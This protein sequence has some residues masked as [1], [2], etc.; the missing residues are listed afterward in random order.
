MQ[1]KPDETWE[2]AQTQGSGLR[3][4]D[5]VSSRI[6]SPASSGRREVCPTWR[7]HRLDI[8]SPHPCCSMG[9]AGLAGLAVGRKIP[10]DSW[11]PQACY[12]FGC[13][14]VIYP[15]A[16]QKKLAHSL[17]ARSFLLWRLEAQRTKGR[18][19]VLH[20]LL[21]QSPSPALG[22]EQQQE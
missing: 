8:S 3:T 9:G 12:S 2:R 10:P 21:T 11:K 16:P 14:P 1:G 19:G 15:R 7:K 17:G 22:P 13:P 20:P 18:H 6:E 5:C 4:P